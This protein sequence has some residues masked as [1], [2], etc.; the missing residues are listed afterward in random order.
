MSAPSVNFAKERE[1]IQRELAAMRLAGLVDP[2]RPCS[3]ADPKAL[4]TALAG[5]VRAVHLAAHGNAG[6]VHLRQGEK[7]IPYP[8]EAFA[9]FFEREP[10]P[11]AVIL[12]VCDSVPAPPSQL[13]APEAPG[14]ARALAEAGISEVIGMYTAIT[15]AAAKEFFTILYR[16]LGQCADMATAYAAAVTALQADIFPNYGFW[17]V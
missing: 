9:G 17:S 14:V 16:A 1:S 7:A 4:S 5:P 2:D 15:P 11:A 3:D 12:S 13:G 10:V 6:E 8:G